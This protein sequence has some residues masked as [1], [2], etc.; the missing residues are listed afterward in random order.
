MLGQL[1][2]ELLCVGGSLFD[3]DIELG[4]D[5][6]FYDAG[7]GCIAV[8]GLPNGGAGGLSIK[9]VESRVDMM[10]VSSPSVRAAISVLL[11]RYVS[12]V[13]ITHPIRSQTR[14]SGKNES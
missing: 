10:M 8:R 3:G 4:A 2:N 14:W 11:A 5:L 12:V 6:I 13:G 7:Q 9:I 1:V